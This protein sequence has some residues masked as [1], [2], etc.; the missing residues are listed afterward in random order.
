MA[1][2][3]EQPALLEVSAEV[4]RGFPTA[5]GFDPNSYTPSIRTLSSPRPLP[6][7]HVEHCG[8]W[9]TYWARQGSL[10]YLMANQERGNDGNYTGRSLENNEGFAYA[11]VTKD[12]VKNSPN[13]LGTHEFF[14]YGFHRFDE[15]DRCLNAENLYLLVEPVR[16]KEYRQQLK[17]ARYQA[18]LE[19]TVTAD[20]LAGQDPNIRKDARSM[21]EV[22]KGTF[23]RPDTVGL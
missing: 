10:Q 7:S 4:K 11:F 5:G 2:V 18:T 6:N 16:A 14:V 15:Y 20:I 3:K 13:D 9:S 21:A 22:Q 19:Q 23:L 8:A 12:M 1:N 17:A